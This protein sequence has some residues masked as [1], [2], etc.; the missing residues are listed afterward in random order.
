[1]SSS[2]I[3]LR[4]FVFV[5]FAVL[6][7]SGGPGCPTEQAPPVATAAPLR[8]RVE[9]DLSSAAS[10]KPAATP[11]PAIEELDPDSDALRGDQDPPAPTAPPAAATVAAPKLPSGETLY[12]EITKRIEV[13]PLASLERARVV[14]V[15]DGDTVHLEDGGKVRLIGINTPETGTPMA[16]EAKALLASLVLDK[17]VYLQNDV[18][19]RDAYKRRL[20]YIFLEDRFVNGEIVR[21]GAAHAYRWEPNTKYHA[22]LVELQQAARRDGFGIWSLP[23]PPASK[24]YVAAK[25]EHMFHRP[26]CASARRA[27]AK[28]RLEYATRD[29]AY[30]AGRKPH[31]SCDP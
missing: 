31:P 26:E 14:K 29:A 1:M 22:K 23:P 3:S 15:V 17:I 16:A 20:A 13:P 12:P 4:L 25:A 8:P 6:V 9:L 2:P 5:A 30:D 11:A 7:V 21:R 10:K 24:V 18:E 27:S 19:R 28:E